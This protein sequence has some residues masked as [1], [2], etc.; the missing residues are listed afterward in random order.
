MESLEKL[1]SFVDSAVL[2]DF[3]E[4][5]AYSVLPLKSLEFFISFY[6]LLRQP[7]DFLA[8]TVRGNG[9]AIVLRVSSLRDLTK[10]RRGNPKTL[11]SFIDSA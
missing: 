3:V 11:E 2:F 5:F 8:K 1:E 9:I 7:W 4:S 6:G 10:S